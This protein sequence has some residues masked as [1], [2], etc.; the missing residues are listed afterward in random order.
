MNRRDFIVTCGM[1]MASVA[2]GTMAGCSDDDSSES[3]AEALAR[4]QRQIRDHVRDGDLPA[5]QQD[6]DRL[7]NLAFTMASYKSHAIA[8]L[9]CALV[10]D[11][12]LEEGTEADA[13]AIAVFI[14]KHFSATPPNERNGEQV[15]YKARL[16]VGSELMLRYAALRDKALVEEVYDKIR[17]LLE[18]GELGPAT[19]QAS[20]GYMGWR[21]F[22]SLHGGTYTGKPSI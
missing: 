1:G 22:G 19:L 11:A 12:L 7:S 13:H 3:Q 15:H 20:W 17:A 9:S 6:L 10:F 2:L 14:S 8:A 21:G 4:L 18:E 16:M 5:A